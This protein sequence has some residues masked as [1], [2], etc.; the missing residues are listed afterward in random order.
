MNPFLYQLVCAVTALAF[1]V[2]LRLA[3]RLALNSVRRVI[4]HKRR[5][6]KTA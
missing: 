3:G 4:P 2:G 6:R 5:G 1:L